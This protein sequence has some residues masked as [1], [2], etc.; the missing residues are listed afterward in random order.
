M[1][2]AGCGAGGTR[3]GLRGAGR[4]DRG[5]HDGHGDGAGRLPPGGLQ[6]ADSCTDHRRHAALH[7]R[8]ALRHARAG[9]RR[10]RVGDPA[11]GVHQHREP[12]LR[13]ARV[14]R[15]V[16][17]GGRRRPPG[18]PGGTGDGGAGRRGGAAAQRTAVAL[19]QFVQVANF[20]ATVCRP[21]PVRGLRVYPPGDTASLF[22]AAAGTG[23]AGTPPRPQADRAD[24]D[25]AVEG[26][27]RRGELPGSSHGHA[28]A[29]H[30]R[31]R[32]LRRLRV[33]HRVRHHVPPLRA[34]RPG[35]ARDLARAVAQLR[36]RRAARHASAPS[37]A[38]RSTSASPTSTWPTTTA[39]PTAPPR[40][41]FGT[42]LRAG[43]PRR[44]RD[45]LVI[46]TKAGYD[47]WPGPYG[48]GGGSRKYLLACLDQ[49]LQRMG[50]DYVDIFYS[51]RFD[52]TTPLEETMGAL[53]TAVRSGQ[54][55]LRRH[56]V[57]LGPDAPARRP[58]S[59]ASWARRC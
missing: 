30:P 58:R 59:C 6:P 40:R 26:P 15:G 1:G 46:S 54:G 50:L 3:R 5:S 22:V 17:R 37:C 18:R 25:G 21:T 12:R 2:G 20:D 45:E 32:P 27:R 7:R 51:H 10:S 28:P 14:P 38:A 31:P 24:G 19:V 34:Q 44:Y 11:T 55:A 35:P 53:D 56:L 43:L 42:H 36:R 9:R 29:L 41:N 13:A 23:C 4:A 8:R 49:S 47:M 52:P 48:Q 39:R 33:R 16:V 57:L